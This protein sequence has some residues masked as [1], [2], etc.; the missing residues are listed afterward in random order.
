M[1]ISLGIEQNV[2]R[3][4]V[5]AL[6]NNTKPVLQDIKMEYGL[7]TGNFKKG[8]SWDII[9]KRIRDVALKNDLV[10]LEVNRGG[11]W[12]FNC[13][14]NLKTKTLMVFSK[15]KNLESVIKKLGKN[16]IH[17]FHAFVSIDSTP[18]ELSPIQLEFLP[19][20]TD[21]YEHRR[22]ED[23]RNLLGEHYPNVNQV[24]FVVFDEEKGQITN[25]EARLYNRYFELLDYLNWTD[26]VSEDYNDLFVSNVQENTFE[27]EPKPIA[28][29]KEV[30]K[31]KKA[32]SE[33]KLPKKKET[34]EKRYKEEDTN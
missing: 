4:L 18:V 33:R 15:E 14:L 7:N 25:V 10:V 13:V 24:V 21:E 5:K 34:H 11:L 20:F 2:I 9:F 1:K 12:T 17:Y 6:T 28:K 30:V 8:G 16:S 23:V 26:Y 29:V 31:L 3:D 19:V 22:L 32:I 27:Q